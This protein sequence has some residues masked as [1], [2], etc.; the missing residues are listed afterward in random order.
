[1]PKTSAMACKAETAAAWSCLLGRV[2]DGSGKPLDGLP[3]RTPPKPA[4]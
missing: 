2:L 1:M 3:S 4:R